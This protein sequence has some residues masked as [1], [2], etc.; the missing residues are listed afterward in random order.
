MIPDATILPPD[1]SDQRVKRP[2]MVCPVC[3]T[4]QH[5]EVRRVRTT[6]GESGW[7]LMATCFNCE[8]V[9]LAAF[10]KEDA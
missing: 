7:V 5:P 6:E 1:P 2:V 9:L 10:N 3:Q 8:A 4:S